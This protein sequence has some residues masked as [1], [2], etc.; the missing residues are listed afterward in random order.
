MNDD[1]KESLH[2]Y[3]CSIDS[4][5]IFCSKCGNTKNVDVKKEEKKNNQTFKIFVRDLLEQ[6]YTLNVISSKITVEQ[7]KEMLQNIIHKNPDVMKLFWA[8]KVLEDN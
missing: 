4:K 8:G 1:C 2:N 6:T 3:Q 7:L 5:F